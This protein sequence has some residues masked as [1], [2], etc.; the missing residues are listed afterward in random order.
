MLRYAAKRVLI[1]LVVLLGA[2][3][4]IFVLI[5]LQPGNP[6]S[7]MIDPSLPKEVTQEMLRKVGYYDP[8][9]VKYFKW[10]SRVFTGDM[11]YSITLGRPVMEV[12]FGKLSNT[13]LLGAFSFILTIVIAVPAG[14]YMATKRNGAV[15]YIGSFLSFLGIS[16]P[17]FFFG[18]VLIKVFT[19]DIPL[20]PSSGMESLD[21]VYTG[22]SKGFDVFRHM[23]LPGLVLS[24]V[25]IA[26][27]IKYTKASMLE[28]IT[29][30]YMRTAKGKGLSKKRAIVSHGLKNASL[31]IITVLCMHIPT[32]L[33]G[34]L[35]TESI[36]LWPGIGRL[37]YDAI[38][39]R[40]YPLIMGILI[41]V[42]VIILVFNLIA[43]ILY[44][45]IDKRIK[46]N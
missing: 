29:K 44:A 20:F 8:I 28:V 38:M 17:T 13:A 24:F 5:H 46:Y 34:A 2:S 32:L 23:I 42:S 35:I 6:Y 19:Y 14:V 41:V 43:D 16:I 10:I 26:T 4:I 40:D 27:L 15:D 22:V 7:H 18:L 37:N 11:G 12:I 25:Q 3:I 45:V 36:F 31:P 1:S 21:K 33:S 30:D 39:N 9:I